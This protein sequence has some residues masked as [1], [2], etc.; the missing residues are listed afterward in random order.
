MQI[1]E[2]KPEDNAD[3][4]ALEKIC[5]EYPWSLD[6]ISE[7]AGLANFCGVVARDDFA[8]ENADFCKNN[9]N[10][11]YEKNKIAGYAGAVCAFDSADIALVAVSPEKRR[12][13]IGFSL[14]KSLLEKLFS[15]GVKNVFLEVR[16]T[17][18]SAKKLYLK[19][20]FSPVGIRKDYYENGED[21]FV[22]VREL[23]FER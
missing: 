7:T 12:K 13:G 3:V 15:L 16:V 4:A 19:A 10:R 2:W 17:N 18:D 20:G 23:P 14:L 6:M 5:F 8:E 21:A 9:E 22:M 1:D 11:A